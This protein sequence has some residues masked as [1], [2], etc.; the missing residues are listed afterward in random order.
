[1]TKTEQLNKLFTKIIKAKI[2]SYFAEY[3]L[4]DQAGFDGLYICRDVAENLDIHLFKGIEGVAKHYNLPVIKNEEYSSLSN[5]Y[6]YIKVPFMPLG[7]SRD[8]V[9]VYQL[10]DK[11]SKPRGVEIETLQNKIIELKSELQMLKS[12]SLQCIP[13]CHSKRCNSIKYK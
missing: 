12:G 4:R 9:K 1:M 2:D 13:C 3:K 11:K 6:Y 7:K 5:D 10:F 8:Y